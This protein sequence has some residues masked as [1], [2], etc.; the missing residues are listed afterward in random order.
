MTLLF[1][2]L[3]FSL[4]GTMRRSTPGRDRRG[5]EQIWR[6]LVLVPL[7]ESLLILRSLAS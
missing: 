7:G 3:G 2:G 5:L 4:S 6:D 1:T